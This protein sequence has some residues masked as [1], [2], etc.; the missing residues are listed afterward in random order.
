[1]LDNN[2]DIKIDNSSDRITKPKEALKA[3]KAVLDMAKNAYTLAMISVAGHG[4]GFA[5]AKNIVDNHRGKIDAKVIDEHSI[6]INVV[7]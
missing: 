4:L 5:I 6:E 2:G 3:Y 7:L 1:M